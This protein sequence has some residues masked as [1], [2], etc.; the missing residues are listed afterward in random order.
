MTAPRDNEKPSTGQGTSRVYTVE[1]R[2]SH[3]L[4]PTEECGMLLD[5]VWRRLY[6]ELSRFGVPSG[7]QFVTEAEAQGYVAFE[8]GMTL[9]YWFLASCSR[10]AVEARLVE[11][12]FVHTYRV[13]R[14]SDGEPIQRA[15]WADQKKALAQ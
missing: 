11:H 1:V 5:G 9:A 15:V 4:P 13:T 3:G 6:P 12:E 7:L 10:L 14:L 8:T 2:L